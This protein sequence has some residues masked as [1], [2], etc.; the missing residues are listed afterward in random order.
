MD[1]ELSI[2]EENLKI[3]SL[4]KHIVYTCWEDIYTYNNIGDLELDT[5]DDEIEEDEYYCEDYIAGK[6][7]KWW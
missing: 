4:I 1:E 6:K 7:N 3:K 2:Y 5:S